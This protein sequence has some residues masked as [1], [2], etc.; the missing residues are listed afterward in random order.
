M[1]LHFQQ[2]YL[3]Q[4]IPV[5]FSI[6]LWQICQQHEFFTNKK[7][8]RHVKFHTLIT[9]YEVILKDKAALS[10]IKW[11][12]L[13]VDE[14]HRLK[15]CEASLYTTLLVWTVFPELKIRVSWLPGK[16][17]L[18]SLPPHRNSALRISFS[19]PGPHCKTA[20]K[21]SGMRFYVDLWLEVHILIV[22]RWLETATCS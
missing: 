19:S 3:L 1:V 6:F 20:L 13:M 2:S 17:T 21:S 12:Y 18:I 14:A 8:G 22:N 10:K 11:N 9:T 5:I 7:G 4:F 16:M 15:N